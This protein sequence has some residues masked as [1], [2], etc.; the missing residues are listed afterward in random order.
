MSVQATDLVLRDVPGPSALGGGWRR[1]LELLYLIAVTEFKKTYFGTVLGYLWSL[2]RPLMLF[3]V[4]VTVFTRI[5]RL[6]TVPHYSVLLLMN[7]VLFG[8]FQEATVIAVGS[9]VGQEAIVRKTQFPRLVIP[10]AVV[11][12]AL[13]NL[14]LNLIVVVI[15]LLAFGVSPEWTWL[16]FPI[17]LIM[18]IVLTTAVSMIVASLYPRYRDVAIIWTVF[19]TVLF[20]ATPIMYA[21]DRLAGHHTLR[22]VILLNPLAPIFELARKWIIQPSAPGPVA[23]AGG[24]PEALAPV[25][26]YLAICVFAVWIFR[27]EAPRIAEAL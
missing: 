17:I 7:I 13:F 24:W 12:T 6:D 5:L 2:A 14:M 27:R 20:Y 11:M 15:F 18:L 8:F 21:I 23:A 22:Q 10:L 4:L 1:S 26:I 25:A 19:S 3:A 9:V 16:L